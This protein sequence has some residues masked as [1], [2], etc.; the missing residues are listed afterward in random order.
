LVDLDNSRAFCNEVKKSST[1]KVV[2][3]V[4]NDDRRFQSIA[5]QLPDAVEPVR[6]YESYLNNF[7]I[8]SG[9]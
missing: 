9:D 8:S 4:S 6:L 7:K 3:I 1:I 5:R 2:Y